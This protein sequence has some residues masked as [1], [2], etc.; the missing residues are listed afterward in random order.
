MSAPPPDRLRPLSELDA[1]ACAG[2]EGVLFDVDD[3][4]TKDGRLERVAYDALWALRDA[5]L[6]LVAVTGRPLGWVDV[7]ARHWPVDLAIGENGAGWVWRE[8]ERFREGYFDDAP[9]RERQR[10]TLEDIAAAVAAELPVARPASDQR[11][12]RCDLAFDVGE[13]V[14]LEPNEVA[15]LVAIIEG[16]GARTT[17]SSV[18]CHAVP[19]AWDKAAGAARAIPA[20]LGMPLEPAAWL[21]VG[22]SGNDEA[23]F[24]RFPLSAAV[25]NLKREALREAFPRFLARGGHGAGFAEIAE[26]LLRERAP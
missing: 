26:H 23:A 10:A 7:L 13:E 2:V 18:H 4:V 20:A 14:Q 8:G 22:D 6:R 9:T 25:A 17:V 19:G 12:R 15:A 16:H 1:P 3:T 24:A 5:G 11:A 21:F